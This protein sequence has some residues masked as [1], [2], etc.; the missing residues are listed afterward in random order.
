MSVR[1]RASPQCSACLRSYVWSVFGEPA[2]PPTALRQQVRGKKKMANLSSTV[3]VRL[4]RDVKRFGRK[5][6]IVPISN[7]RMRNE[8][9]P[10]HIAEYITMPELKTLRISNAPMERDYD[11]GTRQY[12]K[13]F[14]L[15]SDIKGGMSATEKQEASMFQKR[16]IDPTR[17]S[18]ERSMELLE[19]FVP[20]RLDFYR[21]PILEEKEPEP[22][23]E[24]QAQKAELAKPKLPTG[25][26]AIYGS[27]STHDVLV[28]VRAAM[29]EN[30]EAKTV[31]LREDD[32]RFVDVS[33]AEGGE[34]DRIKHI[35]VFAVEVKVK[36]AEKGMRREVRVV[37]Q[38]AA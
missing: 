32:V 9:F 19:I 28:A 12:A 37:A 22:E 16:I 34:A 30:D 10:R 21:Q 3:P 1:P 23:P 18:P 33:V 15:P 29:A 20:G 38:D 4:L 7:G 26:Q 24:A 17:L 5:G 36:G 6:A 31:A 13:Q 2:V 8:W 25:P 35:G 11:F 14:D 27:V